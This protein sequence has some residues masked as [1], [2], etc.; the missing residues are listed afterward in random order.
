MEILVL[1]LMSGSIWKDQRRF[2]LKTLKN[3][4][5]GKKEF[6]FQ[7]N[8]E[9]EYLSDKI[10]EFDQKPLQVKSLIGPSVSNVISLIVFGQRYNFDHPIR[11]MYDSFWIIDPKDNQFNFTSFHGYFPTLVRFVASVFKSK[12]INSVKSLHQ[13][14]TQH[15][16]TLIKERNE[17]YDENL[18]PNNFIDCYIHEIH[19]NEVE[20]NFNCEFIPSLNYSDHL[21]PVNNADACATSFFGAGSTTTKDLLEWFCLLISSHPDIQEEMHREIVNSIGNHTIRQQ[22]RHSMPFTEAVLAE[23]LRFSSS[24]PI[25]LPHM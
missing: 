19:K 23:V 9:V 15:M 11:K 18:K 25:N 8:E 17:S 5:F 16:K 14:I 6:D 20:N 7:I 12:T 10:D 2:S 1:M 21:C 22:D 13:N 3:L 24:I 4:G